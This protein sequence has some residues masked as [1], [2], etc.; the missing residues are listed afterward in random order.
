[1]TDAGTQGLIHPHMTDAGT[2]IDTSTQEGDVALHAMP[3]HLCLI[4]DCVICKHRRLEVCVGVIKQD[5][6]AVQ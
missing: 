4:N 6:V 1:M 5:A 2:V 3:S